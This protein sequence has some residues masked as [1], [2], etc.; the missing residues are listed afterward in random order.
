MATRIVIDAAAIEALTK[1]AEVRALLHARGKQAAKAAEGRSPVRT[2]D[3]KGAGFGVSTKV[4]NQAG[5][6]RVM[7][8]RVFAKDR[9]A[10]IIVL[11]SAK[12]NRKPHRVFNLGDFG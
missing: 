10:N 2:G 7:V 5:V 4:R 3:F 1:T 12:S 11:G 8:S 9:D 6:G